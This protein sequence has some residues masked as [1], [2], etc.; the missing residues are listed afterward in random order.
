MAIV[1]IG[2]M[3]K[4]H[5]YNSIKHPEIDV[6]AVAD[7]SKNNL[8]KAKKLGIKN[9]YEDY[10]VL[11][12]K[13]K[14]D[15][16]ILSLP[17]FLR[18]EPIS[19][20]A[21]NGLHVMVDKPL[22]RTPEEAKEI[23][24]VIRKNGTRVMVSTNF[25]FFPHVQELKKRIDEGRYGEIVV[26]N[27]DHIM[28]GPFSHP[29]YPRPVSQWWFNKSLVGGGALMDNGHHVIDLFNWFFPDP[30]V[31]SAELGY[32]YNLQLE[33]HAVVVVKSEK[34]KTI[35]LLNTGWYSHSVFPKLDFRII[36]HGSLGFEN[37]DNLR[38]NLYFNAVKVVFKNLLKKVMLRKIDYLA[39]TYYFESYMKSLDH[40]YKSIKTDTEFSIT[41]DQQKKVLETIDQVYKMKGVR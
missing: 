28:H 22:S 24:R 1:G 16:I 34:T 33:D 36:I 29:L 10:T 39:Y 25:R 30:K 14:L 6:V 37:T 3:G 7:K 9:I 2:H 38:P 40:F 35:G 31:L 15:A 12:E 18:V 5:L 17:N 8:S 19:L 21:E 41:L 4:T 26:A 11:V 27:F 23:E 32:H 13:E 20:A